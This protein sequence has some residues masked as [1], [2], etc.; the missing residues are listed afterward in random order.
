VFR[1]VAIGAIAVSDA[2][3]TLE[4]PKMLRAQRFSIFGA[5]RQELQAFTMLCGGLRGTCV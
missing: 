2:D 1:A 5:L 3:Q 4:G